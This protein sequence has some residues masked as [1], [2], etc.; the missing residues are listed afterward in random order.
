MRK[1]L[2]IQLALWMFFYLLLAPILLLAGEDANTSLGESPRQYTYSWLFSEAEKMKPRGGATQGP[3][4]ELDSSI[5][6]LVKLISIP[7][8]L[9]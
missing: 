9:F 3:M 5:S 1:I 7:R 4:I 6:D 8:V 2:E